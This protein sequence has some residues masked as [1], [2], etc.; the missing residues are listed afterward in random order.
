MVH[1]EFSWAFIFR[2]DG[3]VEVD[4]HV[5]GGV[6]YLGELDDGERKLLARVVNRARRRFER[7]DAA[8]LASCGEASP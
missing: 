5:D 4:Q 7:E 6:M 1:P 8:A 2:A 3:R